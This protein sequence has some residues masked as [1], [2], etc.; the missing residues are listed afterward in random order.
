MSK[1]SIA[2]HLKKN[3]LGH[4]SQGTTITATPEI[5]HLV[6]GFTK[7]LAPTWSGRMRRIF[8]F[9]NVVD[10]IIVIPRDQEPCLCWRWPGLHVTLIRLIASRFITSPSSLHQSGG[11]RAPPNLLYMYI[12]NDEW[13]IGHS[14]Y[15]GEDSNG[16]LKVQLNWK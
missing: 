6:S 3:K 11:T 12:D 13:W 4:I 2:M 15:D 14:G 16:N 8:V 1:F 5:Q 7:T 10:I 9:K